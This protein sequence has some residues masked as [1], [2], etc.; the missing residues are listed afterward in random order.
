MA[1]NSFDNC[2]VCKK[3][4]DYLDV[5]GPDIIIPF[6]HTCLGSSLIGLELEKRRVILVEDWEQWKEEHAH[7]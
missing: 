7:A 4:A 3:E 6:C 1:E 2:D 5:V